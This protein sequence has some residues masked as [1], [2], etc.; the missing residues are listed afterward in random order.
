MAI[1]KNNDASHKKVLKILIEDYLER[2]IAQLKDLYRKHPDK[3][4]FVF[5]GIFQLLS[6]PDDHIDADDLTGDELEGAV[7]EWHPLLTPVW[8]KIRKAF[9][10]HKDNAP[11]ERE[12]YKKMMNA[13]NDPSSSLAPYKEIVEA[14]DDLSVLDGKTYDIRLRRSPITIKLSFA[15]DKFAISMEEIRVIDR[16]LLHLKD[17]PTDIFR[18]CAFCGKIIIITRKGKRYHS[19]CAP[20]AKQKERWERDPEGCREKE[21]N[22]YHQRVKGNGNDQEKEE[23]S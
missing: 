6:N 18:A 14:G 22:R 5:D 21:R 2:D 8:T 20:K 1:I 13:A 17:A 4:L 16:F 10:D 11:K 3:A 7:L 19:G 23:R 15:S 12:K 9:L